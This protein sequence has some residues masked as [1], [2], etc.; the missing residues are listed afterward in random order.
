MSGNNHRK[1]KVA[2]QNSYYRKQNEA[3]KQHAPGLC[4]CRQSVGY[5]Q[6]ESA[7]FMLTGWS[8]ITTMRHAVPA[9]LLPQLPLLNSQPSAEADFS[10]KANS[11]VTKRLH[12]VDSHFQ[13]YYTGLMMLLWSIIH[14][15]LWTYFFFLQSDMWKLKKEK[16]VSGLWVWNSMCST[17]VSK[18]KM[19]FHTFEPTRE[20]AVNI[21]TAAA[22]PA[23][24]HKWAN[25]KPWWKPHD[26][27][28][29]CAANH[30]LICS[31]VFCQQS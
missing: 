6:L 3:E 7:S 29:S 5:T 19:S 28:E 22:E 15:T 18:V 20:S 1:K 14:W 13:L 16:F 17:S 24:I 21:I 26:M 27:T 2:V 9:P 4:S 11:D 23:W 8:W 10:M 25:S 12:L 31:K 30:L